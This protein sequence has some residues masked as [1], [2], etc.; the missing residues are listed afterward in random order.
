M[1][2][3]SARR[4]AAASLLF[5]CA[6]A[7]QATIFGTVR[8]TVVDAQRRPV[9]GAAV[10]LQALAGQWQQS[11][12]TGDHGRYAFAVVPVGR[13]QLSATSGA[14]TP[15]VRTVEVG[16]GSVMTVDLKLA[17]PR[18]SEQISVSASAVPVEARSPTTQTTV[19]RLQIAQTPGASR[20]NSTAIITDFVPG[21]TMVHDQ[22]HVR[23]GH[24]VT[25]MIDGIP[26]PNTN[27]G[28]NVGPQFDPK[29]IDYLEV[30]RG[31]LSAEYGDR[32]YA[33]FNVVPRTGF[34]RS[35]ESHLL[36]GIGTRRSTDDQFDLGSHTD[37]FAYY[38]SLT[39]NRTDAGLE[40]PVAE[41][42]HDRSSGAGLFSSLVFLPGQSDQIRV[43]AS[44]RTDSYE[45]PN[46][47][48]LQALGVRDRQR[49]RDAFVNTSWLHTVSPSMLLTVAP[50]FHGNVAEFAGGPADP[51]S[52][53]DRRTSHYFGMQT[54]LSGSIGSHDV[55][56]GVFGFDEHDRQQFALASGSLAFAQSLAPSGS[57]AALFAEDDVDVTPRLSLRAGVRWTHFAGGV[58]ETAASPRF[59][60]SYRLP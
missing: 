55:R 19:S 17:M 26:V 41:I 28:G 2:G 31:G 37:R 4:I 36:L 49:E 38:A 20:A 8:G 35:N 24:Q 10:T 15:A 16:S 14:F 47:P 25:W 43:A 29:D 58:H 54:S 51:V 27:I 40:P 52:T 5:F 60:A 34:E 50:F 1:L 18:V 7:A 59:G 53:R 33:V 13:Y 42:I 3:I 56:F 30:Q 46:D 57:V 22:L 21:A 12:A 39:G 32:T 6:A 48:E 9:A 44:A 11:A 45:I 23:G